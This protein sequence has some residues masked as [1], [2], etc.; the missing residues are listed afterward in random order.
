MSLIFELT[1]G[2]TCIAMVLYLFKLMNLVVTDRR[3]GVTLYYNTLNAFRTGVLIKKAQERGVDL[4]YPED[5]S[6][7][8][9]ADK[10]DEE[11]EE[12]MNRIRE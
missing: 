6:D 5:L 1:M 4:V 11:V 8:E 10:I 7:E 9:L 3:A 2:I 12:D